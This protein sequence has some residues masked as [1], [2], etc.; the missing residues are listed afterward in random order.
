MFDNNSPKIN[1]WTAVSRKAIYRPI[2]VPGNNDQEIYL[3]YLADCTYYNYGTHLLEDH[4]SVVHV[5]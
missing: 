3:L 2:F 4:P 5:F 1:V